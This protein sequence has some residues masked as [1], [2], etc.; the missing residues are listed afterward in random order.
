[1]DCL[2][3]FLAKLQ[4]WRRKVGAGNAAVFE[5]LSTL[6]DEN[7]EDSLLDPLLK[8]EI[9]QHLRSMEGELTMYFREFEEEEGKLVRNPF[10]GTLD[11]ATIPSDVQEEFPDLKHDSA[12][13]DLS[14]EKFLNVFKCSMHQSYP[15]VSEIALR[16]LLSF[17]TP[18]LC[19]SGFSAPLQIKNQSRNRLD[20]D[21]DM[22][23]VLS[24]TQPRI[25]QLTDKKQYQPSH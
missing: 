3:G 12:A 19:E 9:T 21:P 2:R 24:V 5:N 16:L 15:K 22:R 14:E 17:S 8:T 18:C 23:C 20:V 1:M 10:S 6:L 25:R 11:I 4:N 13:K 7:E